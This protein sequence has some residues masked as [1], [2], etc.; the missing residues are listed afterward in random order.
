LEKHI[1]EIEATKVCL[2]R[3][4]ISKYNSALQIERISDKI[5]LMHKIL[6]G[7][8]DNDHSSF[9]PKIG[10]SD[11]DMLAV[12]AEPTVIAELREDPEKLLVLGYD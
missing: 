4:T 8:N 3:L 5:L 7:G 6:F 10:I 1:P 12:I 2:K 11:N 9:C